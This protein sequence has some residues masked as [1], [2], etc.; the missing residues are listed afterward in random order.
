MAGLW[1]FITGF[2]LGE[3][4]GIFVAAF[5]VSA[6]RNE[7]FAEAVRTQMREVDGEIAKH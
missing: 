6:R 7:E 5:C 2:V 1:W 3:L 4:S